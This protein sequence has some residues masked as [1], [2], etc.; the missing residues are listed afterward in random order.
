MFAAVR[1]ASIGTAAASQYEP[2]VDVKCISKV[3]HLLRS[4]CHKAAQECARQR[5]SQM[6]RRRACSLPQLR[7][8]DFEVKQRLSPGGAGTAVD[9]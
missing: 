8:P 6:R 7:F 2:C 9:C 3:K 5:V 4:G 1:R